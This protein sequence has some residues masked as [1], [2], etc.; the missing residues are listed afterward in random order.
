MKSRWIGR[1]LT[2]LAAC[3]L[4]AMPAAAQTQYGDLYGTATDE[5]G[6]P[7]PGVTITVEGVGAPRVQVT[8][9]SGNFRFL[10]LSP[11]A[12]SL[13]AA[14]D[15]FS[16]VEYPEVQISLGGKVNL[17]V[18]L[19]SSIKETI[20]VT[21]EAPL[22]DEKQISRGTNVG[23]AEL[24][25]V[26]TARDPWSLLTLA[27]GVQVDRVNVGG[28]ES[29]QQ[30]AFL[31]PGA[32]GSENTF[33]VDGVILTDMAAVG[34][35]ATYFDFG[36]FEEVQLTTSS[37]DVTVA[38]A[39]VTVNQV[40]KRGTNDWRV[41]ARYLRTDGDFQSDPALVEGSDIGNKIDFVEEYGANIGGPLVKDHL[42]LWASYGESD[43]RNLAPAPTRDGRL[44][45][46]TQLEDLNAKLNFQFDQNSGVAHYWTNDKLKFGRVISFLG[47]PLRESTHDQTT[48]AD[49]YKLE[50]T[51]IFG[52]NFVLTG[53][54][55]RNEGKF[56]LSPKGGLDADVFTDENGILHGSS[57]DFAQD[58]TIEQTRVD[59]N[60]FFTTGSAS[61]ELKFGG[62]FREQENSSITVWPRGRNVFGFG[63]ELA[64]VRFNR[65]RVLAVK[66][67]YSS[68]WVQD[69]IAFDR[70]T[71]AAGLRYDK[72]SG[73]NL[74]SVSPANPQ[75]QGYIPELRFQGNDADGFEWESVVPRISATYALG[76]KR[77]T[78]LRASFSQ[79]AQQLGQNRISF[80]NPAGGYSYA[81]F[82]FSDVNRN[83][84]LDPNE[85]DSLYF[86]YTYNIDPD[87][88]G[89]LVSANSNDPNL[90]P[91]T[92]DEITLGFDKALGSSV[93]VGLNVIWRNT[94]DLIEARGLLRDENGQLRQWTRDDF[95]FFRNFV[96]TAPDGSTRTVPVF[97]LRPGL[98]AA[99]GNVI[100]NGDSEH[101]Y[102]GIS[103]TFNKRLSNRWSARGYVSWNDWNWNIGRETFLH[104]DPTNTAGDGLDAS[105]DDDI[106]ISQSGGTKA[107]VFIGSSWSFNA[108]GLYQVAPDRPWGF[109]AA[110]SV[111]GREG[112]ASPAVIRSAARPSGI[113]RA[114]VEV[115]GS[116]D[117]FRN[118]DV[119]VLD[120]RLE[121]EFTVGGLS[122]LVGL[123][124]F[125]LT[126]E[127]YTLQTNRRLDLGNRNTIKETLSPRIFRLGLTVRYH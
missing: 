31:A 108:Y 35:S 55:S 2:A 112:Y 74:P 11:G 98:E 17:Q 5:Q 99:G 82:Y 41:E 89:S 127:A 40:T 104:D 106:F 95:V 111:T 87:N 63:D 30:S 3:A 6:A 4:L 37:A 93:G 97:D 122:L 67:E 19:S 44:S 85:V 43:I 110:L 103:A 123:D 13:S 45:D 50:D 84:V 33:S 90:D 109:N 78:L 126:N 72:Q 61:H 9:E 94:S 16:T 15:G 64:L 88:P 51:H 117:E 7:L 46:I 52:S 14:L 20:T 83:L 107:D 68:A 125:N 23:A 79:Y 25:S 119:I 21:G 34:A 60:T 101:E 102:L 27:P 76:E 18:Q 100:T 28:N 105:G 77:D 91:A 86:G 65:N 8:D 69:S 59:A 32:S 96:G 12:Y 42:W 81:Y 57:F 24:D 39:G 70:W 47:N 48:P 54:Y 62:S 114:L 116:V 92:T 75:A 56:T 80:V 113:G 66:T 115:G 49:I 10:N 22:I 26:P 121:K 124:G 58:A 71:I 53:L 36:A 29:G 118:D 1:A 120:A 73:E 38:T